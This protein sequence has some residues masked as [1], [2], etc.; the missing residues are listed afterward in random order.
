MN[1]QQMKQPSQSDHA[2]LERSTVEKPVPIEVKWN[3]PSWMMRDPGPEV[4]VEDD[5]LV[6]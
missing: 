1:K 6:D 3:I 4:E 2:D 5:D